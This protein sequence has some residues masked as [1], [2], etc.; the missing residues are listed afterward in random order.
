MDELQSII[1]TKR[2]KASS[3]G[4]YKFI[5]ST[6]TTDRSGDIIEQ[7]GWI[8][9]NYKTNPLIFWMHNMWN[10][11]I[12]KGD[13]KIEKG[14]LTVEIE[15][16]KSDEFARSIE[17]KV[18]GGFLN[19]VSVGF[20]GKEGVYRDSLPEDH[21]MYAKRGRW[22]KSAELVE[23]S[24]VTVPDNPEALRS[25]KMGGNTDLAAEVKKINETLDTIKTVLG[26]EESEEIKTTP[27]VEAD[28][29]PD[30][31][32]EGTKLLLQ[33]LLQTLEKEEV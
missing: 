9:D 23:I 21:P 19:A 1:F 17:S 32:N 14:E 15:F 12:G 10:P 22:F 6:A 5:A 4:K 13:A 29:K 25:K 31:S 24:I 33:K 20:R 2:A 18:D 27:V 8:L 7:D 16:D 26:I 30:D 11:P 3:D 28:D